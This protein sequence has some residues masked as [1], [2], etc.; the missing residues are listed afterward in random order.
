M[1]PAYRYSKFQAP[2]SAA[3]TGLQRI[4]VNICSLTDRALWP[5]ACPSS[6]ER[7]T[8]CTQ[9]AS[10]CP[11]RGQAPRICPQGS[12]VPLEPPPFNPRG[13]PHG[14]C[15][16]GWIVSQAGCPA[17]Q[18]ELRPEPPPR[19]SALT[20]R[21]AGP[22]SQTA[23]GTR[24]PASRGRHP[25]GVTRPPTPPGCAG[26]PAPRRALRTPGRFCCWSRSQPS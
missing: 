22:E 4:S 1:P 26:S 3:S 24:R 18:L 23:S 10:G 9:W 19:G 17:T 8:S 6:W 5:P 25:A 15:S 2:S 21:R 14:K 16:G 13:A 20:G 11:C 7:L 12:G